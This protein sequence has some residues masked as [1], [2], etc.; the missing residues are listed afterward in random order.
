MLHPVSLARGVPRVE[1]LHLALQPR[2]PSAK[3]QRDG[4]AGEP[5]AET[6]RPALRAGA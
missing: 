5:C 1:A 6:H 4:S 2:V 3:R